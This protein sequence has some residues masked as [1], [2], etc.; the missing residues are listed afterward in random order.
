MV[1]EKD[2]SLEARWYYESLAERAIKALQRDKLEAEYVPDRKEALVKVLEMIP[3][4]GTIGCGDSVTLHQIGFIDWLKEQ[5][6]HEVFNTFILER[7]SVSDDAYRTKLFEI[8]RKALTA[9]IFVTG[10]NAVTLDG[11]LVN[12]DGHG[13][14]VAAMIFGPNRVVVVVGVN[15]IVKDVDEAIKKIHEYTAPMNYK[16][17]IKKHNAAFQEKFPCVKT[18]ICV[19]CHTENKGCQVLTIIGGWSPIVK[20]SSDY[21]HHIIIVGEFLGI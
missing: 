19:D 11:K 8:Q 17:H 9:N 12:M 6:E 3:P 18:G 21:P 15:K 16:R 20:C 1:D 13:N 7:P 10:T 4:E 5:K 14:R 2:M